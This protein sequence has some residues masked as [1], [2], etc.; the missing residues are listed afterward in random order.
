M[1]D[2]KEMTSSPGFTTPCLNAS[3]QHQIGSRR[4]TVLCNPRRPGFFSRIR[5]CCAD[6]SG[7]AIC[8]GPRGP[9]HHETL[10]VR[11]FVVALWCTIPESRTSSADFETAAAAL[12]AYSDIVMSLCFEITGGRASST[13]I[14]AAVAALAT[15]CVLDHEGPS[16]P[17]TEHFASV[18]CNCSA[19]RVVCFV[20][21]FGFCR[22]TVL[23][24]PRGPSFT[25]RDAWCRRPCPSCCSM[26]PYLVPSELPVSPGAPIPD[27]S[28]SLSSHRHCAYKGHNGLQQAL[29]NLQRSNKH[30]AEFII[31]R[32]RSWPPN[33]CPVFTSQPTLRIRGGSLSAV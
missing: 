12:P 17:S 10:R 31:L 16:S 29:S 1:C 2:G 28:A 8:S 19:G 30:G 4:G 6:G 5:D 24:G 23:R 20:C 18:G 32:P 9:Q 7:H 3:S 14:A 13:D 22:G 26:R 33:T 25:P 11:V 15:A 27:S 21:K